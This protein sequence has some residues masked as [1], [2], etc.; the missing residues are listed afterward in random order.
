MLEH[1]VYSVISPEG[2]AAILWSDPAKVQDAAGALKMTA[3]DLRELGVI[4]DIVA[5]PV[6]G[7]HRDVR[8]TAE[9]VA[10]SLAGHLS[11]LGELSTQDLLAHRDRKYRSMGVFS[12]PPAAG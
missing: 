2:C 8:M 10:K 3:P 9:R 5:E 1:A 6:G 11:Q 7:A 4:D 12:E